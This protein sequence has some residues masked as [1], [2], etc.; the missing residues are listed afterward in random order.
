MK[1]HIITN[2]PLWAAICLGFTGCAT[3]EH[4]PSVSPYYPYYQSQLSPAED[5]DGDNDNKGT[6]HFPFQREATGR[7]VFIFD[8]NYT[9]WALYDENGLRL[10]TGKASGG[11]D[12]CPDVGRACR[13]ITGRYRIIRKGGPDCESSIYP[14]ETN[15]GAPMPYCMYFSNWGYAVHG[16]YDIPDYNA[17]HGCIRVTPT[18]AGWLSTYMPIGT[19]MIVRPYSSSF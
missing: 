11:Q 15:G 18:V 10:N 19:T 13:T 6:A 8:P 12:F 14:I 17:S 1:K 4:H 3:P 5:P 9:A 7:R 16:S 2:A